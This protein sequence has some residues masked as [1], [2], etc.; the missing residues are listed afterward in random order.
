MKETRVYIYYNNFI[1]YKLENLTIKYDTIVLIIK[2]E[3]CDIFFS[4][5]LHDKIH[6]QDN[7]T[8]IIKVP[9]KMTKR[10]KR[11]NVIPGNGQIKYQ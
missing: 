4:S 9:Q 6:S 10:L 7:T 2:D 8:K 1:T 11:N 3:I 5:R